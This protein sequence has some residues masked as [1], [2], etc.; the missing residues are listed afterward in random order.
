PV[1]LD[2]FYPER[3]VTLK[4]LEPYWTEV[5]E[6]TQSN[7]S[8]GQFPDRFWTLV[9]EDPKVKATWVF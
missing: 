8:P 9:R 3:K 7:V 5:K 1:K 2:E 6:A 4:D